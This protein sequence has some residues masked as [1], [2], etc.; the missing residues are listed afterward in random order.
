MKLYH[1]NP[2]D[3]GAEYFIMSSS[4]ETALVA[5][6]RY[7]LKMAS[8]P[9]NGVRDIYHEDYANL[10]ADASVGA[11]PKKYTIDEHGFDDIVETEIC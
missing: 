8:D 7:Y 4:K 3:F 5:L 10:W 2:N 11:L 6:K 9:T 1:I